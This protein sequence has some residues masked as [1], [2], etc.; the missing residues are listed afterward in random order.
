MTRFCLIVALFFCC[1]W[2]QGQEGDTLM[3]FSHEGG[4]YESEINLEISGAADYFVYTRD[5]SVPSRRKGRKYRK[6]ISFEKTGVIRVA[7]I[8]DGK[9]DTIYTRSYFIGFKSTF[10]V[11]SLVLDSNSLFHPDTGIY[12]KGS[13]ALLDTLTH[14]YV[15]ANYNKKW[16]RHTNVE[17]YDSSGTLGFNQLCGIRIFGGTTR[18]YAEKAFRIIARPRYG[19][20]KFYYELFPDKGRKRYKHVVIR[21]SGN[22]FNRTRFKDILSTELIK[23]LQI[24]YQ[25]NRPSVLF[26]NGKFWGVYNLREKINVRMFEDLYGANR[27]SIDIIQG[28][29]RVDAGSYD[30]YAEFKKYMVDHDM[31]VDS[32][33]HHLTERMDL[34]NY[35]NFR[36]TQF[37]ISNPDSRGNI[38]F[39][40]AS[41]L[42]N[43]WR[44]ILYDTDMGFGMTLRPEVN[45]LKYSISN[46]GEKWYNP[47]W[48]TFVIRQL[49]KNENFKTDL[50]NQ[51]AHL[52]NTNFHPDKVKYLIDSLENVFQPEM[53]RHHEYIKYGSYKKWQREVEKLR[54]FASARPDYLRKNF[55]EVFDLEGLYY[56]EIK[57]LD[58]SKATLFINENQVS[59]PNFS[60]LYFK[61][62]D[63]PMRIRTYPG[64]KFIKWEG[65]QDNPFF[66]F[67]NPDSDT[68]ILTP[69]V[70][71]VADMSSH[72]HL[73]PTEFEI[74]RFNRTKGIKWIEIY[75][76]TKDTIKISDWT[77]VD[78]KGVYSV[79]VKDEILPDSVF[80]ILKNKKKFWNVFCKL[81]N[82]TPIKRMSQRPYPYLGLYDNLGKL[83]FKFDVPVD[84][85][86][87]LYRDHFELT[88]IKDTIQ[89]ISS[90][91]INRIPEN[92]GEISPAQF[93]KRVSHPV[94]I[95]VYNWGMI[96]GLLIAV[97]IIIIIFVI[98]LKREDEEEEKNLS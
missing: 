41:N 76:P 62:V 6:P 69:I 27:D 13:K 9:V 74:K 1:T 95:R 19:T 25:G 64:Y 18:G 96:G 93:T 40:R 38:R 21:A 7:A 26:I 49:L 97:G 80:V 22:E 90:W 78:G 10:P 61:G 11:V 73:I 94:I 70:G 47:K 54:S 33:Y 5:G 81:P 37:Y 55:I 34:R 59:T 53:K 56:L 85:L 52:L 42:D 28:N 83:V 67:L 29:T 4:F 15:D 8:V 87:T 36:C 72:N 14:F 17:Y 35:I 88:Y 43:K 98:T 12:V 57:G 71:D 31:S 77:W 16:E 82:A 91:I 48:S 2:L 30:A 68:I 23:D 92:P 60:G 89:N 24:D 32:N 84:T 75:N 65:N 58:T 66:A 51:T 79:S 46:K 44:W 3:K 45:F 63:L 86:D 50:I 39:W 20:K